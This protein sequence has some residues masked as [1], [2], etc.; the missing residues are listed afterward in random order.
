MSGDE[1]NK[2]TVQFAEPGYSQLCEAVNDISLVRRSGG[3][4]IVPVR[5]TL[6]WAIRLRSSNNIQYI[7]ANFKYVLFVRS[8]LCDLNDNDEFLIRYTAQRRFILG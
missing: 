6:I 5:K 1:R 8:L 3:G 4:T 2:S 7:T